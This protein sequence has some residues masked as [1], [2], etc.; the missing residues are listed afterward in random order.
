MRLKMM[1][2]QTTRACCANGLFSNKVGSL[3][4]ILHRTDCDSSLALAT[5]PGRAFTRFVGWPLS[6][7]SSSSRALGK[8]T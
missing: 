3:G 4:S 8:E 2:A 7:S 6:F 5:L 1:P